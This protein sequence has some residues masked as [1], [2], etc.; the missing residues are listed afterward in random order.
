MTYQ[1]WGIAALV[2][3]VG[4]CVQ[5]ANEPNTWS[6]DEHRSAL[7]VAQDDPWCGYMR[8][9]R[10]GLDGKTDLPAD[11][12]REAALEAVR[13]EAAASK[14]GD[15]LWPFRKALICEYIDGA[16]EERAEFDW[17]SNAEFLA[18]ARLA[19]S[20]PPPADGISA[21][22]PVFDHLDG[23]EAESLAPVDLTTPAYCTALETAE[24]G[25]TQQRGSV[26]E[27]V[28]FPGSLR[29]APDW[30]AM[31]QVAYHRWAR[32]QLEG[33]QL[34]PGPVDFGGIPY[35]CTRFHNALEGS[36]QFAVKDNLIFLLPEL[37]DPNR[38]GRLEVQDSEGN[39]IVL[40]TVLA[41]AQLDSGGTGGETVDFF[42]EDLAA[43]PGLS[44]AVNRTN[45]LP[46][47]KVFTVLF[48]YNER[49]PL[50]ADPGLA[51]LAAELQT[52]D[53]AEPLRI[54][55][56]GHA[57]CVGP[58]WYNQLI[59]EDRVQSVFD[60]TIQP[61]LLAK[62][63]DEALLADEKRFKLVG[64]GKSVP[65]VE[66]GARCEASDPDRRVVVVVQ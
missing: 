50:D 62:G 48:G 6:P 38:A 15:P 16:A 19:A 33:H 9:L 30:F 66:P 40:D 2:L 5:N 63:F 51:A 14:D 53:P 27:A 24:R 8:D 64:L 42:A 45:N 35:H 34:T 44:G 4:A 47:P 37:D 31:I 22:V 49:T 57:D 20:N 52:R 18:H 1:G 7:G 13:A 61:I 28:S 55:M 58:R 11:D 56:T 46:P 3:L 17:V 10:A 21:L 43:S 29:R 12:V 65:A 41:A 39:V 59:S 36:K 32:E 60:Q 54:A 25:L 23:G 26:V